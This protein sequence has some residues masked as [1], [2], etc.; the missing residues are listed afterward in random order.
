MSLQED[1]LIKEVKKIY[2]ETVVALEAIKKE[3]RQVVAG[4]RKRIEEKKIQEIR[5]NLT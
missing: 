3:Y 2:K 1:L 4:A 5:E